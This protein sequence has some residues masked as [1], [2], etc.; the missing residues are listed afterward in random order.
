MTFAYMYKIYFD[1]I[2]LLCYPFLSS[3]PFFFPFYS[4]NG[5]ALSYTYFIPWDATREREHQIP[6]N[7]I[8]PLNDRMKIIMPTGK[9]IG[10]ISAT[11]TVVSTA[12]GVGCC[13]ELCISRKSCQHSFINCDATFRYCIHISSHSHASSYLDE[14][15]KGKDHPHTHR[16]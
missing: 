12:W 11:L 14:S 13:W 10:A 1:C 16:I 15:S 2:H 8:L 6:W 4:P 3:S 5:P 9:K 7:F